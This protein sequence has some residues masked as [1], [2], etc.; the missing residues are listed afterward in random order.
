MVDLETSQLE[1]HVGR[2][3]E[4]GAQKNLGYTAKE[5]TELTPVDIKP[6]LDKH[7][8]LILIQ[9]L[10]NG[11]EDLLV[12][13]TL[14][15]RKDGSLYNVE[16]RLQFAVE[17]SPP[18]FIALILDISARKQA[19]AALR[20]S[21]QR[22]YALAK[23]APVGIFRTDMNGRCVYVNE[24]WQD[25]AGITQAQAMGDGW[26]AAIHEDDRERV[27]AAWSEA[28]QAQ[29]TFRIECRFQKPDGE[30]IWLLAQAEAERDSDAQIIGYVG[31][32]TDI[33]IR[34]ENEDKLSNQRD[35]LEE[36]VAERTEEL[37]RTNNELEAFS[38]S[39]S[40][41]LRTP[42]R[43]LDGF[44]LILLEDYSSQLDEAGQSYLRRIRAASQRMG[45]LIDALL[46]L[47]RVSRNP[48][49]RKQ[50]ALS[51]LAKEI[52]SRLQETKPERQ[53][54][55]L[56]ADDL[57]IEG[58]YN[59]LR[60]LLENLLSNAWKYTSTVESARIEFNARKENGKVVY[61][62]KDNGVGFDMRYADK[63]FGAFQR[64]HGTEFE[65]AGIGLATV[66]RI[67][68]HHSGRIWAEAEID[69]GATFS[70]T[71]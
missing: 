44:S 3:F 37:L 36:L 49:Q 40:H 26:T 61:F 56:I 45:T 8:F 21:N 39:V 63:L 7:Q 14:H 16:I 34:K 27:F 51:P 64:L 5:L 70:F 38:Y 23:A 32:V 46:M 66:Q 17:E 28:A 43:A 24:C 25:L 11:E 15:Q 47:S 58:D 35:L 10:L 30:V 18:V 54:E 69:K 71:F 60:I 53:V 20:E 6:E 50:V 55:V 57:Y 59:L 19:D 1:K 67:T 4:K 42:L 41:D 29:Q 68:H 2:I 13:E 12:F 31:T 48:L 65:G 9:P 33:S 52:V 22:Y 62:V